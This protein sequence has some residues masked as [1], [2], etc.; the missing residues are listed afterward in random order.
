MAVDLSR[1][2]L[3]HLVEELIESSVDAR[4]NR[5][6]RPQA[7]LLGM[8]RDC[9]MKLQRLHGRIR[10]RSTASASDSG[11]RV[12]AVDLSASLTACEDQHSAVTIQDVVDIVICKPLRNLRRRIELDRAARGRHH[13]STNSANLCRRGSTAPA[14]RTLI[15]AACTFVAAPHRLPTLAAIHAIVITAL[16]TASLF[17]MQL[18]CIWHVTKPNRQLM[19]LTLM[20]DVPIATICAPLSGHVAHSTTARRADL[21]RQ[22]TSPCPFPPLR[23]RRPLRSPKRPTKCWAR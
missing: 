5:L 15:S 8:I 23:Q 1:S 14:R 2:A 4:C 22:L 9:N 18:W 10:C 13:A 19:V 3:L 16:S 20:C 11:T 17:S 12:L 6:T 21:H 7:A